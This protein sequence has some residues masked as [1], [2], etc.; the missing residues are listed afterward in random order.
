MSARFEAALFVDL[1]V[2]FLNA[3]CNRLSCDGDDVKDFVMGKGKM[4]EG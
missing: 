2:D 1:M 3:W 4:S